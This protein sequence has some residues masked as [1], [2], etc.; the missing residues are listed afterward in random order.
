M[1]G[2]NY[3]VRFYAWGASTVNIDNSQIFAFYNQA[4]TPKGDTF[5]T[6][7]AT[8]VSGLLVYFQN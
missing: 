4:P 2:K 8:P 5:S 3:E 1:P 7:L 6:S